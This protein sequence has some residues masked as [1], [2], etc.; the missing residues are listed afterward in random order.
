MD[1]RSS[2]AQFDNPAAVPTTTTNDDNIAAFPGALYAQNLGGL[3]ILHARSAASSAP[4]TRYAEKVSAPQAATS[5]ADVQVI[6]FG[7]D[8]STT[9]AAKGADASAD[10]D[11][12]VISDYIGHYGW[13]QFFWTFLLALFQVPSTFQIFAFVF[14]VGG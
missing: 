1:N 6:R 5:D 11:A 13:W 10:C 12:D 3:A 8:R 7:D 4:E 14:Q 2:S 9:A